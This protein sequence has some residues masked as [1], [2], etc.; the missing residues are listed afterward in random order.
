MPLV[1]VV[2]PLL[3]PLFPGRA[4][5]DQVDRDRHEGVHLR[6]E[7]LEVILVHSPKVPLDLFFGNTIIQCSRLILSERR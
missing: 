5:V 1:L 7:R 6:L 2:L 3:F 4:P